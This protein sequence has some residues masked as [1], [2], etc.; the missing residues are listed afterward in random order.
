MH[1][2]FDDKASQWIEFSYA[3]GQRKGLASERLAGLQHFMPACQGKIWQDEASAEACQSLA[4]SGAASTSATAQ[5]SNPAGKNSCWHE[6]FLCGS[7]VAHLLRWDDAQRRAVSPPSR[8][9]DFLS[10]A[11]CFKARAHERGQEYRTGRNGRDQ[12]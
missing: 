8:E 1:Q 6:S 3:D 7:Q 5:P 11:C 2:Q 12:Q 9:R 10:L 4:G